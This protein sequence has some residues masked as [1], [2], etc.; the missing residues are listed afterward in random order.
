NGKAGP[1]ATVSVEKKSFEIE[2]TIDCPNWIRPEKVE[3]FSNGTKIKE[4]HL[5]ADEH[6]H[7]PFRLSWTV[8]KPNHDVALVLIGSGNGMT[9][10]YWA[11]ARPYQPSSKHFEQ[12]VIG[13]TN[14]VWI[15][16]DGD[17]QYTSP[18]NYAQ[19]L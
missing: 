14:P 19:K 18:R 8:P 6:R 4:K 15:D 1:G 7:G 13:A 2:A 10:P 5:K 11:V 17:G 3:L 16:A 12:P 9:A